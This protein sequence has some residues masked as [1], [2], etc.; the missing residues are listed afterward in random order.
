MEIEIFLA[1][2]ILHAH[3]DRDLGGFDRALA[4]H[5]EFLE[6]D[7]QLGIGLHQVEHVGHRA[8]AVTAIVIEELDEGDVA[9]L[10]A[11][12]HATR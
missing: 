2:R 3:G 6:H 11:K 7:L 10:I 12:G 1:G 4:Q 9:I 5:R 8:F